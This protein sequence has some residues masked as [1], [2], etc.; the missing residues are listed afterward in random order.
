MF[1][2]FHALAV[3]KSEKNKFLYISFQIEQ[4]SY[5]KYLKEL[6]D[7]LKK[8][9]EFRVQSMAVLSSAKMDAEFKKNMVFYD[10]DNEEVPV[11]NFTDE[12]IISLS[13]TRMDDK[14]RSNMFAIEKDDKEFWLHPLERFKIR[15]KEENVWSTENE[16]GASYLDENLTK[17]Y[18]DYISIM[19][20]N[21][22]DAVK[23]LTS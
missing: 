7:I 11:E 16:D 5:K 2:S 12:V 15:G 1:N 9:P 19:M 10:F 23:D 20:V 21:Q 4:N 17:I 8:E 3:K 13:E 22:L 18:L 14:W 6:W